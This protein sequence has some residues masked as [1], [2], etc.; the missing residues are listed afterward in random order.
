MKWRALLQPL[1]P[2]T[3]RPRPAVPIY[4]FNYR[5][6]M[7]DHDRFGL[8]GNESPG[9][10]SDRRIY[11]LDLYDGNRHAAMSMESL[12]EGHRFQGIPEFRW[13]FMHR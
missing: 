10:H 1:R 2:P 8:P 5:V 6:L 3:A 13:G 7:H 11:S 9:D 12:N 4:R